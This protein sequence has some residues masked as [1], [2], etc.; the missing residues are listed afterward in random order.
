MRDIKISAARQQ[1]RKD[2]LEGRELVSAPERVFFFGR[3][4]KTKQVNEQNLQDY[5]EYLAG[6]AEAPGIGTED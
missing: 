2:A 6:Y 4:K 5:T 3:E 1:G